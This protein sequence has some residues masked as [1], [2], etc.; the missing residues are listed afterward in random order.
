M[1]LVLQIALAWLLAR[2]SAMLVIPGTPSVEH[3][4]KNVTAAEIRL[5]GKDIEELDRLYSHHVSG[6]P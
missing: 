3:L 5:K 2:S 6:Q 1:S 4:E